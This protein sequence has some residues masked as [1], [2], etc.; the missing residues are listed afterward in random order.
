MTQCA[1]AYVAKILTKRKLKK[2]EDLKGIRVSIDDDSNWLKAMRF[3]DESQRRHY[4]EIA[5]IIH[6]NEEQDKV[7]AEAEKIYQQAEQYLVED[8]FYEAAITFGKI[9]QYKDAQ[10]RSIELWRQ[11]DI[12]KKAN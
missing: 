7:S 12:Q 6:E 5:N 10:K 4:L 11:I 2:E 1:D 9:T 8:K 3:A